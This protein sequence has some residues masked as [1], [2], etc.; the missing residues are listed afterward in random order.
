MANVPNDP[1]WS[2]KQRTE[3]MRSVGNVQSDPTESKQGEL[4]KR[5]RQNFG[6]SASQKGRAILFSLM[7]VVKLSC[8]CTIIKFRH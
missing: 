1:L 4:S 7:T 2:Q 5:D 6:D 8:F 3:R